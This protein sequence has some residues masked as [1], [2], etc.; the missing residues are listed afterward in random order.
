M[1]SHLVGH[2]PLPR[3][4]TEE[5]QHINMAS[6]PPLEYYSEDF[7]AANTV[8]TKISEP[9]GSVDVTPVFDYII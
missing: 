9:R 7:K 3:R 2:V 1:G 8:G 4:R 5:Q 6:I